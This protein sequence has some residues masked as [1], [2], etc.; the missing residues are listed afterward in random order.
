[1][2][3]RGA[4]AAADEAPPRRIPSRLPSRSRPSAGIT[5]WRA[6]WAISARR[7]TN[8][9]TASSDCESQREASDARRRD[10]VAAA[11]AASALIHF[12]TK[13]RAPSTSSPCTRWQRGACLHEHGKAPRFH[14]GLVDVHRFFVG[15][16]L[17]RLCS[18]EHLDVAADPHG[19]LWLPFGPP[20]HMRLFPSYGFPGISCQLADALDIINAS[21]Q[22]ASRYFTI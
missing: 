7:S 10:G 4:R 5:S 9:P 12:A 1:V 11:T 3:A 18:Q 14:A 8:S 16:C 13:E 15:A 19:S 17:A 21:A 22:T 20:P 2:A 6:R